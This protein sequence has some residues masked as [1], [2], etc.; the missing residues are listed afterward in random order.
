MYG[1]SAIKQW[2]RQWSNMSCLTSQQTLPRH[3]L[4]MRMWFVEGLWKRFPIKQIHAPY[5]HLSICDYT[6]CSIVLY[7][8]FAKCYDQFVKFVLGD[9][10]QY[11]F[12]TFHTPSQT[13]RSLKGERVA[14]K[15]N[16]V[17]CYSRAP[18]L[19]AKETLFS[20]TGTRDDHLHLSSLWP[21][22]DQKWMLV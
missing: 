10:H 12:I 18:N 17:S 13:N 14:L 6:V 11:W 1:H 19:L 20:T 22:I 4:W 21:C 5:V 8:C 16:A 15:E 3:S 7:W 9:M 2:R